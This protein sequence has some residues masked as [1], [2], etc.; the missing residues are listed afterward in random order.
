MKNNIR[1]KFNYFNT[2]D[3]NLPGIINK[4][5][6]N[7]II[8][9]KAFFIGNIISSVESKSYQYFINAQIMNIKLIVTLDILY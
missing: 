7:K 4:S 5:L 2:I 9:N 8:I 1:K 6:F 3:K